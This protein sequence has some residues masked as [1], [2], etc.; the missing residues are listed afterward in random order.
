[1]KKAIFA[2]SFD[3]IHDGHIKIIEKAV[4]MFDEL[5]VVIADNNFKNNQTD[6][7][8]RKKNV[9]S[10]LKN[11]DVNIDILEDKYIATYAKE[12]GIKYLVRSARNNVDFSYEL[13]MA[14]INKKINDEIETV[15]IIPDYDD[16]VYSS[17]KFR[18]FKIKEG[19]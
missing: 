1:M 18:D 16:I 15:L 4:K 2:G 13:D 19:K 11:I 10:V 3:P 6:L 8:E 7:K 9:E 17:T 5:F 14:K 12:N